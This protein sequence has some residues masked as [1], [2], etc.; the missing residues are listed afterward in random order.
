MK[1]LLDALQEGRL[2]ELPDT[3]KE[4]S[5]QYLGTLIEAVPDFRPGVDFNAAV[6]TREKAANTGITLGWACPHGRVPGEGELLCAIG[7]SPVGIA[8]G[9]PDGKPV[10]IVVM[11]YIPDSQKNVYL[12]EI[13]G[14]A[15]AIQGN[16]A[17]GE[18]SSAKDLGEVRNRLIDL[19]TAAVESAIPDV[20]ARMIQLEAKQAVSALAETL[21]PGVLAGLDLVP[22][23][24]VLMPGGRSV[25]LAQDRELV[26]QIE[27]SGSMGSAL[28][29]RLPFDI[30]GYRVITR[31][32]ASFAP[33]RLF[34][35]CLAVRV[36]GDKKKPI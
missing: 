5:L 2:I 11:H 13:S 31:S 36:T 25:V 21:P 24:V 9:A 10:H 30:A 8:Y 33:D 22:L 32:V 16:P 27:A 34:Y 20:K 35:D 15:K 7:W 4:R 14:L 3:D 1:S 28:A 18:L 23:S 29:S 26:A 12:R 19:L 6:M 17:L